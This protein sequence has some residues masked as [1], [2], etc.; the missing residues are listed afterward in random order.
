MKS[1]KSK[2]KKSIMKV[3]MKTGRYLRQTL[4]DIWNLMKKNDLIRENRMNKTLNIKE[5]VTTERYKSRC[6]CND[7]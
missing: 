7:N 4:K 2:S 1:Y 6:G 3:C 5:V